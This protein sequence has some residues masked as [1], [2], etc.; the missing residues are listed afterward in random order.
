MKVLMI[1]ESQDGHWGRHIGLWLARAGVDIRFIFKTGSSTA[2]FLREQGLQVQELPLRGRFDLHSLRAIRDTLRSFKPDVI[3]AYTAKTCWLAIWAQW[4]KKRSGLVY[5]RGAIRRLLRWN[6]NDWLLFFSDWVDCIECNSTAIRETLIA[7]GV[8][9]ERVVVNHYGH[10]PEWYAAASA[11]DQWAKKPGR[12]RIGCVANYRKVKGLETL[13]DAVDML[14]RD[15]MDFELLL[16]GEDKDGTLAGYVARSAGR[17]HVTL[18]GPNSSPWGLMR[19]F[20]CLVIPSFLEGLPKVAVESL[21]CGIPV[22]ASNVGGLPEIIQN[23]W[24]GLLVPPGDPL[25]LA[26]AISSFI[27]NPS[28]RDTFR[29]NGYQFFRERFHLDLT[30]NRLMDLYQ[31]VKSGKITAPAARLEN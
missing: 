21:A 23:E 15:G 25:A 19:T 29:E 28:L 26:R 2:N 11:P 20:D 9:N 4:P 7:S 30:R 16:V 22:I 27:K 5:Y 3:H 14:H 24:N 8:A 12:F 6:P 10:L 13:V 1:A 31:H 18:T 17:Q